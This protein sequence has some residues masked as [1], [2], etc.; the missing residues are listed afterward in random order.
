MAVEF[1]KTAQGVAVPAN[2]SDLQKDQHGF[3]NPD[4]HRRVDPQPPAPDSGEVAPREYMIGVYDGLH[5]YRT[6]TIVTHD[7][8]STT[9]EIP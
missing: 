2:M 1:P 7:E 4:L 5:S 9:S 6:V 3:T 8:E